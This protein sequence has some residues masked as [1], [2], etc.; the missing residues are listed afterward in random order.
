MAFGQLS[1][2]LKGGTVR[3]HC[4]RKLELSQQRIGFDGIEIVQFDIKEVLLPIIGDQGKLLVP[5]WR[6]SFLNHFRLLRLTLSFDADFHKR[7]CGT[8]VINTFDASGLH[9]SNGEFRLVHLSLTLRF[10]LVARHD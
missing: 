7:I 5:E 1:P 4:H 3:E 6:S 10:G 9:N 2:F 8:S